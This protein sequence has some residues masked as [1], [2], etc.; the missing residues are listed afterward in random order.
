M[1][2]LERVMAESAKQFE[3]RRPVEPDPGNAGEGKDLPAIS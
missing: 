1:S 3:L 2:A